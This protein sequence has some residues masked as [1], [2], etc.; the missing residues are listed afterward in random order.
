[1]GDRIALTRNLLLRALGMYTLDCFGDKARTPC[2]YRCLC[3]LSCCAGILYKQRLTASSQV[4]SPPAAD[5]YL[6]CYPHPPHLPV[7]RL[8]PLYLLL[9]EKISKRWATQEDEGSRYWGRR[10]T[11]LRCGR[12]LKGKVLES[13][14]NWG[15]PM[16]IKSLRWNAGSEFWR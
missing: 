1:M 14:Q 4:S 7:R 3:T 15:F 5:V 8:L 16:E 11:R 13:L 6:G 9:Q 2:Q 10:S 12:A